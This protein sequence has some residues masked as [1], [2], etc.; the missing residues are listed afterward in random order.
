[1]P[2]TYA[3]RNVLA[4]K[5]S[6]AVTT[7]A[8]AVAV[9][10]FVVMAATA[11]GIGRVAT[12]T[13]SP[14]N[15]LVMSAGAASAEVS[16]LDRATLLRARDLPEVARGAQGEP[17][18]SAELISA[19]PIRL[20]NATSEGEARYVTLRGVTR[21]AFAVHD[22][23]EITA[24]RYPES[25]DEVL[26]GRLL[27]RTLG[28]VGVGE[29]VVIGADSYEISGMLEAGG[30]IFDGEAWVDLDAL[31]S[32]TGR[33]FVSVLV[34]RLAQTENG[35]ASASELEARR[36]LNVDARPEQEYYR[37]IQ[38]VSV[39]FVY[40][41]NLIGLILGLG[42]ALAAMNTL[43]AATSRR[44]R[45]LATLRALGF[46][47]AYVGGTVLLESV[48]VGALG[49]LLGGGLALAF[50]G[51]ALNLLGLSF[52]LSVRPD[53]LGRGI[54]LALTI[55]TL[56]GLLPARAALG[57]RIVAALRQA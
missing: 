2:L 46:G 1:M 17:L 15:L 52:E 34:I 8:V 50:D 53:N 18:A 21:S 25:A 35:E 43:Y 38:R 29:R 51:F 56:G 30:Q 40:L 47:R 5:A 44:I 13:G 48:L 27:A 54:A 28:G 6:T 26:V 31:Q 57:L 39:P 9:L 16:Y 49:G 22:G 12:S 33:R 14:A 3:A 24:G 45:E 32:R 41:G 10:V 11:E 23:L 20:D 37:D 4:R 55:G 36:G 7:I 42:A 19:Q